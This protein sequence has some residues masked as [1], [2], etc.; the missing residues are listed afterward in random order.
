MVRRCF[1]G[2]LIFG[3]LCRNLRFT[4]LQR[5]QAASNTAVARSTIRLRARLSSGVSYSRS[6]SYARERAEEGA[7]GYWEVLC[8]GVDRSRVALTAGCSAKSRKSVRI[9]G[10]RQVLSGCSPSSVCEDYR[11]RESSETAGRSLE[12]IERTY[13]ATTLRPYA[14]DGKTKGNDHNQIETR[15]YPTVCHY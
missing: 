14:I 6:S 10:S 4:I 9:V 1:M 5:K 15:R 2:G 7:C 13:S 3:T 8:G 12:R 11:D